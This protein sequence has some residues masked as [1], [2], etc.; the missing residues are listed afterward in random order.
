[1][2]KTAITILSLMILQGCK[3][4]TVS[5][6]DQASPKLSL[7]KDIDQDGIKN[8]RDKCPDVP[9]PVE[10]KGCPWPDVDVD[11]IPDKDD[12]CKDVPGPIENNG[13]PWPDT[14]GDGVID[15][16]DAC[17]DV[18]GPAENNGCPWPDTDGDGILDKDDACP[19]VPGLPEYN[20]CPKPKAAVAMEI[21]SERSS[22]KLASKVSGVK[23]TRSKAK[24]RKT[25][26]TEDFPEA[27]QLTAGEVNDFSKWNYWEDMAVPVLS[28]YKNRWKIFPDKRV[29]VQLVNKNGK[30]VI[31]KKVKL[32][33][34]EKKVVWQAISDNKGNAELWINPRTDHKYSSGKYSFADD[35][36]KILSGKAKLFRNGQN[37]ISLDA[38]CLTKRNLDLAFVIDATGSMGDEIS[39]LQAELLDV[40]K[41]VE[42]KLQNTTDVRYSSVFYRDQGDEYVTREFNFTD[43]AENLI[44]FIKKQGAGGGGDTPEAVVEALDASIEKLSWSKG[45]STKIMFLVLDAPPHYSQENIDKIYEKIKLA[46][47]KGITIIPLAASDTDKETEY[48]M[49]TFALLTNG[50]YTFLT[51]HSGIGNN[52]MEPTTDSYEVEKLNELLLRLILQRSILPSCQSDSKNEYLNK[53]IET[54]LENEERPKI[55]IYPNPTKGLL[56]IQSNKVID[57]LYVY[58]FSGKILIRKEKLP[59]GTNSIDITSYPQSIYLMRCRYGKQ[60]DTFKIVK[61]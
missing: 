27:G 4:K 46:A 28:E 9:G 20:G 30:P 18:A 1:M 58:D 13:C 19:T 47:E 39:Y 42:K 11:G 15:K 52:H 16:D 56:N 36:G 44:N 59:K 7:K 6:Q 37:I 49:R 5:E 23:I 2:K 3:T 17:P 34:E 50:T 26:I 38:P 43:K 55:K 45:N 8:G 53:K 12:Q 24:S 48:I 10:N 60:W 40:L 22:A 33:N 31:G 32:L 35:K 21:S 51:N 29:S 57:E 41:K 61:N 14:D 25:K 54:E